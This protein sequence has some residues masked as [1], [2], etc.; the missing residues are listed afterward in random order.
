MRQLVL[1][2]NETV[3]EDALPD[4]REPATVRKDE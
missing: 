3:R 4:V 2:M 1:K